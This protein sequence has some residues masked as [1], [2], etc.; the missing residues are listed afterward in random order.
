[1]AT[2]KN[3]YEVLAEVQD[4]IEQPKL[5]ASVNYKSTQFRY[6]DLSELWRVVN[7]AKNTTGLYVRHATVKEQDGSTWVAVVASLG[8]QE[9]VL[10]SVPANLLGKPQDVGS[11]LTYAKRYSLAMAFGLSAEE[12]DDG[13]RG[14]GQSVQ[15]GVTDAQVAKGVKAL[16]TVSPMDEA[17]IRAAIAKLDNEAAHRWLAEQYVSAKVQLEE[18][19]NG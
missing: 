8:E 9:A 11:A 4:R 12:D 13:Q 16:A 10:A 18:Q 5:N 3:I 14:Q 19:A 6:A 17:T 15:A 7:A 1:M 2:G